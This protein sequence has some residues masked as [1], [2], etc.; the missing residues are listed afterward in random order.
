MRGADS[1]PASGRYHPR[2]DGDDSEHGSHHQADTARRSGA[3]LSA[4]LGGEAVPQP[5]MT[6]KGA[7]RIFVPNLRTN[8]GAGE[9]LVVEAV[10]L[11][12]SPPVSMELVYRNLPHISSVGEGAW[13]TVGFQLVTQ[14]RGV[15]KI[16]SSPAVTAT[17]GSEGGGGPGPGSAPT[18]AAAA[19]TLWDGDDILYA[20][21]V[22][23]G[24]PLG[25]PWKALPSDILTLNGTHCTNL[26][27]QP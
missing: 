23:C 21:V 25:G 22:A 8:V 1:A 10:V 11:S 16:V 7:D 13:S 24:S 12:A 5:S 2:G 26:G 9:A 6:H 3:A 4:A 20:E 14:G 18:A 27:F 17:E 15:Y 19:T